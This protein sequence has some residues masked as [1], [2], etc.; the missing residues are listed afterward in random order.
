MK[1]TFTI[2]YILFALLYLALAYE[3]KG[4]GKALYI[5]GMVVWLIAAVLN[6]FY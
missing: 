4:A 6:A 5:F 2:L 1:T 3:K